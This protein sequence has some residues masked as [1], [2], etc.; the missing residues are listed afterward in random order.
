M[1]HGTGLWRTT[2]VEGGL[3]PDNP[4]PV[5]HGFGVIRCILPPAWSVAGQALFIKPAPIV[6]VAVGCMDWSVF[7]ATEVAGSLLLVLFVAIVNRRK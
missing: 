4:E 6:M 3:A 7:G 2:A 1:P 5:A